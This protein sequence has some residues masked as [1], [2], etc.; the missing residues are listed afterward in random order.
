MNLRTLLAALALSASTALAVNVYAA[1]E[2]T[3]QPPVSPTGQARDKAAQTPGGHD[4]DAKGAG[5]GQNAKAPG[6]R[7]ERAGERGLGSPEG[8]VV[9]EHSDKGHAEGGH[10]EGAHDP[11]APPASINFWRG[12]FGTTEH[13]PES[14]LGQLALRPKDMPP[15]FLANLINFAVFAWVIWRFGRKPIAESLRKRKD[16]ILHDMDAARKMKD[17]AEKRLVTYEE[18]LAKIDQ[19]IERIRK[20]F[21]EQGERDKERIIKDAE[22]KRDRMLKDAAFLIEQEAK[23]L[24][25]TLLNET[26]DTA[27]RAAEGILRESVRTDDDQRINDAFLRQLAT[28]HGASPTRGGQA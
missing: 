18:R 16:H 19:E 28:S 21:R 1:P 6:A 17:D 15:P 7:D 14:F 8:H 23:Q 20:D 9:G 26:V 22:E 25:I 10:A 12:L 13:E 11:N 2:H 4:E 3:P 27:V 24:R 5:H